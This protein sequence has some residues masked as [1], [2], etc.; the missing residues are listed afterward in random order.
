M[1]DNNYNLSMKPTSSKILTDLN[2]QLFNL[3]NSLALVKSLSPSLDSAVDTVD[4]NEFVLLDVTAS[5]NGTSAEDA[6]LD[7]EMVM[8]GREMSP[9]F[10]SYSLPG[11]TGEK[12]SG[13]NKEFVDIHPY[14]RK[15]ISDYWQSI[16]K[17]LVFKG[18][19]LSVEESQK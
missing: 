2:T 9:L 16:A 12:S 8:K 17:T 13:I 10:A 5:V 14:V 11:S 3:G 7:V 1:K 6:S 4:P 15:V 18:R 19:G